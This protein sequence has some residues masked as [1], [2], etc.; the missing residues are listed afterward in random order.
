MI[1]I[2][3]DPTFQ[4]KPVCQIKRSSVPKKS[5]T[6]NNYKRQQQIHYTDINKTNRFLDKIFS[7]I[8]NARAHTH[9]IVN[10]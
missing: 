5:T 1:I 8:Y 3:N 7:H 9:T 6:Y 4:N 10:Q 2:N